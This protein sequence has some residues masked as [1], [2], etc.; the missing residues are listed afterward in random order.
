MRRTA[1][2]AFSSTQATIAAFLW[3]FS[4][5]EVTMQEQLQ[6]KGERQAAAAENPADDQRRRRT[7]QAPKGEIVEVAKITANAPGAPG[8]DGVTCNS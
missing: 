3:F 4:L 1:A 2:L 7:W 6:E 8:S 5:T